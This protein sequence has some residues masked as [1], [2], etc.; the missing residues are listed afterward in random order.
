MNQDYV[1]SDGYRDNNQVERYN[2]S[3]FSST[4]WKND[5]LTLFIN[6]TNLA[7]E[8][9]S[10]LTLED[11][12]QSPSS[13]ASNWEAVNGRE[14]YNRQ[15]IGLNHKREFKEKW[16]TNTSVF[17]NR[18]SSDER[19]PFN[20]ALV[21][22]GSAG[23]RTILRY[24]LNNSAFHMEGGLEYFYDDESVDLY[25]TAEN[26]QGELLSKNN[27]VRIISNG[28][29]LARLPFKKV[30]IEGGFSVNTVFYNLRSELSPGSLLELR[31]FYAPITLPHLSI[32]YIPGFKTQ[33]YF[34]LSQGYSSPSLQSSQDPLEFYENGLL[35]ER[36]INLELGSRGE[37]GN[38]FEY[39]VSLYSFWVQNLVILENIGPDQFRSVNSG[40]TFHPGV[41]LSIGQRIGKY[42]AT[43]QFYIG[44]SYQYS[45]HRFL[46][47]SSNTSPVDGNFLPGNPQQKLFAELKYKGKYF[48][49]L[50]HQYFVGKTFANDENTIEVDA[51]Q[52]TNVRIQSKE[53]NLL[54]RSRRNNLKASFFIQFNNVFDTKYASMVAV[55]PSS[56]GGNAPRYLYPGLPR[57]FNFGGTLKF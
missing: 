1:S 22:S 40:R 48:S 56:F 14:K 43:N 9:P 12:T 55:N 13:A 32:N 46:S 44:G 6:H 19:R 20:T 17:Y 3:A 37:I 8:I 29:I 24:G 10:S 4:E 30:I 57:N 54:N 33:V 21:N 11:Y 15:L 16:L 25:E 28:F 47:F 50:L 18:L 5:V 34:N 26:G 38:G 36:G 41:E 42:N 23:A 52:L 39:E 31:K 7:G 51:Y 35:R 2:V 27:E 45:P 53:L 49:I